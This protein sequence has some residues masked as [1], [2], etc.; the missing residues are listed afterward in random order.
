MTEVEETAD[1][2]ENES[3][4]NKQMSPFVGAAVFGGIAFA[5]VLY[6]WHD[7][8]RGLLVSGVVFGGLFCVMWAGQYLERRNKKD[9]S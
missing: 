3:P 8:L 2:A 9:A 4:L 6:R 7:L 1:D 5:V